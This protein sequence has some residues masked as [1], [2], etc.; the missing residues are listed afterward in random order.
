MRGLDEILGDLN[1]RMAGMTQGQ[2]DSIINRLF[3]KTDLAAV[4]GLLAAQ[5]EQWDALAAQIDAAG[6][7]MA[8]MAETQQDNLAGRHDVHELRL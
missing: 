2:K 3:N 4:N 6:G 7:A 8:Q 1:T 5:G